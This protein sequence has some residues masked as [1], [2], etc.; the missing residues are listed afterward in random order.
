MSLKLLNPKY[1]LHGKSKLL[2]KY[3]M[4]TKE[5]NELYESNKAFNINQPIK[6]KYQR[7]MTVAPRPRYQL[8][9]DLLD[10]SDIA[11]FN[12]D[13]KFL[14]VAID[15]FTREA[16]VVPQK[17]KSGT[18]TLKSLEQ[19]HNQTGHIDRIQSDD[20][21][22]FK[23]KSVQDY[24]KNNHIFFFTTKSDVKASIVERFNRTLR[25]LI[26][27]YLDSLNTLRY[28][29]VLPDLV[30][31]YNHTKH[32]SLGMSPFLA[33]KNPEQ[34][35]EIQ[36]KKLNNIPEKDAKFSTGEY[37]RISRLKG[38]FEKSDK[39]NYSVEIFKIKRVKNTKP[40]TYQ[41]TDLKGEDI[42]GSF[43]EQE[44]IKT[45]KPDLYEIEEIIETKGRGKN[46]KHL[47]KWLGYDSSFNS[48]VNDSDIKDI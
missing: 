31:N 17:D 33:K 11:K 32:R 2:E 26:K 3:P 6:K 43:Y 15:I 16:F 44:L 45:Y 7:R 41:L 47:V 4:F 40:V 25:M 20:G 22:E 34:I 10:L 39:N 8:Q 36:N 28:I 48:W 9:I 13:V 38:I 18:S 14:L 30:F 24:L 27:R 1:G 19:I 23:N 29:D 37:V 21:T 5:I 12:D 35:L 42:I 46:K